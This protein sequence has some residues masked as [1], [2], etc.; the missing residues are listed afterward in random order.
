VSRREKSACGE[1]VSCA[2]HSSSASRTRSRVGPDGH[3]STRSRC[4]LRSSTVLLAVTR[5]MIYELPVPGVVVTSEPR[6]GASLAAMSLCSGEATRC[7]AFQDLGRRGSGGRREAVRQLWAP[8]VMLLALRRGVGYLSQ[9]SEQTASRV[10]CLTFVTEKNRLA[11][12]P[13]RSVRPSVV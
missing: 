7:Q 9:K 11:R 13:S 5:S 8:C 1:S 10:R 12:P 2:I 4:R 6:G 3:F